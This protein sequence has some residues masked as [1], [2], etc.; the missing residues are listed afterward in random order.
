MAYIKS[1]RKIHSDGRH[2]AFTDME[3][4]K[5]HYYVAFRNGNGHARPGPVEV[6]GKII[7]IRSQDLKKWEVCAIIRT[8][9]DDR[10]PALLDLGDELAVYF[11][12]ASSEEPGKFLY[13]C[14]KDCQATYTTNVAFTSDGIS[15]SSPQQVY[16]GH[17]SIIWQVE[18]FGDVCYGTTEGGGDL[19]LTRSTDGRNWETVSTIPREKFKST[20]VGLWITEDEVMHLVDRA[21]ENP[22]RALLAEASPPYT[23]WKLTELNY[24]VHCPV[25]RPVG[26]EL[27]VAGK[28]ITAQF[29]SSLEIPP[30]P[31]PEKIAS[32]T[33]QDSRLAKTP[34]DWHTAIWRLVGD[35][36]EPILVLPSRGDCGYPGLVVEED[37]VLMSFYSQHDVDEGPEP[38][39]G[40][41]A[42]EI[43]LAEIEL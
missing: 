21:W 27:W 7:V 40:E 2:N 29:P 43:Y 17:G 34:Q 5:G 25:I 35:H 32:L 3:Y 11:F 6:Q 20:E 41:C 31:S 8:D 14:E 38:K 9:G 36:L 10:D 18:R 30:E 4:W 16:E 19:S 42:N 13:A 24:T 12:S 23:D 33:R 28:T 39:P 26:D 37:R 15:W 1:I 22:D